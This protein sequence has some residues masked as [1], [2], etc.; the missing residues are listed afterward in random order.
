MRRRSKKKKKKKKK[1]V[2]DGID[3]IPSF[4][5][6]IDPIPPFW[7]GTGL[8]LPP[9]MIWDYRFLWWYSRLFR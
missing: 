7:D 8:F 6:G 9:P 5:D 4:W 1:R 2:P 3:P